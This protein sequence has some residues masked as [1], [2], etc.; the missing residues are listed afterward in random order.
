MKGSE[1]II[2]AIAN[3]G[4]EIPAIKI[5]NWL[6]QLVNADLLEMDSREDDNVYYY[7]LTESAINFLEKKGVGV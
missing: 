6:E 2:R 7:K 3:V 5:D 1:A 4:G